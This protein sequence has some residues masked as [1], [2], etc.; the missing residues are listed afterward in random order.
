MTAEGDA[1]EEAPH[2][3]VVYIY[4]YATGHWI[5]QQAQFQFQFGS[6]LFSF[7]G[8]LARKRP[9]VISFQSKQLSALGLVVLLAA[10]RTPKTGNQQPGGPPWGRA[11]VVVVAFG[12][13][14]TT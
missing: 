11:P 3:D 2:C 13:G 4:L 6:S 10:L 8:L 14:H 7:A 9:G 12:M 5:P 1:E